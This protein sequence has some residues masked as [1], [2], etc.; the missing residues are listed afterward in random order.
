MQKH[1]EHHY[2]A[3][4]HSPL[5]CKLITLIWI[6]V[7]TL[8]NFVSSYIFTS[9]LV[10]F[11]ILKVNI[12]LLY[13]GRELLNKVPRLVYDWFSTNWLSWLSRNAHSVY[14]YQVERSG[15]FPSHDHLKC[16]WASVG[17]V[18]DRSSI[19]HSIQYL[20]RYELTRSLVSTN[21][22][23]P[24]TFF[25]P[26]FKSANI[27]WNFLL[28]ICSSNQCCVEPPASIQRY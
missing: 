4:K 23:Y 18:S 14:S 19:H 13:D 3:S 11:F 8:T 28:S 20:W 12:A 6:L 22:T 1:L 10:C 25:G 15:W 16:L 24:A 7:L 27:L 21:N 9:F 2:I 26:T 17:I 5:M